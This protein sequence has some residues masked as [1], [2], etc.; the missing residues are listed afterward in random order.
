MTNGNEIAM[1]QRW[2]DNIIEQIRVDADPA[3]CVAHLEEL[4]IA[5]G[6]M[7]TSDHLL[8]IVERL[9]LE[10]LFDCLNS[11]DQYVLRLVH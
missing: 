6:T 5:I 8:R 3:D 9:P 7:S 11:S 2:F 10:V 1:S 4:R